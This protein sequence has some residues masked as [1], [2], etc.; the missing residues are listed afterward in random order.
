MGDL[1][2]GLSDMWRSVLLFL[3]KAL[4]FVLILVVGYV[5]A[6]LVRTLV[7][8][9]LHRVG[10]DRAVE[11]GALGR[12]LRRS[13]AGGAAPP[14]SSATRTEPGASPAARIEPGA[15]SATRTGAAP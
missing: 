5:L 12:L 13:P 10:F 1:S 3:P 8:R 4:A 11:R 7:A 2:R 14:A 15:S 6:R 9:G